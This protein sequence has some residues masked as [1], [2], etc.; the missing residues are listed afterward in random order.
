LI[1]AKNPRKGY[2]LANIMMPRIKEL[3]VEIKKSPIPYSTK[4]K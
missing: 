2:I 4:T 3:L 1:L